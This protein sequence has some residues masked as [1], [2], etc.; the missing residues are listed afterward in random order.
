MLPRCIFCLRVLCHSC[1]AGLLPTP[2]IPAP[3]FR[4]P[5]PEFLSA[6]LFFGGLCR[7]CCFLLT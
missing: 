2:G 5:V 3:G 1:G 6:A 4:L 7:G